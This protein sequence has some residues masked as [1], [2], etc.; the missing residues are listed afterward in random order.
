MC[1][2]VAALATVGDYIICRGVWTKVLAV[3]T[4]RPGRHLQSP[5]VDDMVAREWVTGEGSRWH[6]HLPGDTY[7][8]CEVLRL[9]PSG[10]SFE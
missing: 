8:G 6:G 7:K 5:I 4:H 9:A 10:V 3:K 2:S 1:Y